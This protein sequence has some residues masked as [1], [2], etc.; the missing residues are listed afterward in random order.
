MINPSDDF[1]ITVK[2]V[3][4]RFNADLANGIGNLLA[5]T[6]GMIEKYFGS[7]LPAFS[8]KHVG[9]PESAIRALAA[10]L[11]TKVCDAMDEVR[12]ADALNSIWSLIAITDKY[13]SDQKP[14]V[15]A[16]DESEEGKAKLGNVLAH[17]VGSLRMVG[18]L[19]AAFFPAKLKLL[20]ESLGEDAH[21]M[22][23][24]I[25]RAK[26]FESIKV[27]HRFAEI[28]K[29]YMRLELP[30]ETTQ[31][32]AP[33]E[34]KKSSAPSGEKPAN[35]PLAQK[36]TEPSKPEGVIT[37]DDFAKVDLRVATV[38]L[39][40]HV[41]GSDKLLHLKV[42][43]GDLGVK[44]IFAGIRQWVKPEDLA[45]RKVIIVANLQPRKMKFGTSE[46]MLL[47]TDTTEGSVA[48]ILLADDLKEGAR[49]G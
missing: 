47:A 33:K 42:S 46:G 7:T 30:A 25:L 29:L 20:L 43:V 1:E 21:H 10:S 40:E 27:G 23:N 48:P 13:I 3:V 36:P 34:A 24:A 38:L 8:P 37:I 2:T 41:P 45:N 6:L 15:L 14:W 16:K 26:N 39:V 22:E 11:P 28:P 4:E 44:D 18:L 12:T 9:E 35:A 31:P 32:Q 49:L 19:G 5:R 17:A